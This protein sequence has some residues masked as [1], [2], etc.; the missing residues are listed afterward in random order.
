MGEVWAL[1]NFLLPKVFHCS[2]T[3]DDW[4]AAPFQAPPPPCPPLEIGL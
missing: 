2:D 1:L 4:F 3:F